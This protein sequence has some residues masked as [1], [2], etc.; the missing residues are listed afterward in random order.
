MYSEVR[1]AGSKGRI[2]PVIS[3]VGVK[4]VSYNPAFGSESRH[5]FRNIGGLAP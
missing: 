1:M 4:G 3:W 5:V 2:S